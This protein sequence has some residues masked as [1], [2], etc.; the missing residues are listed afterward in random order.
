MCLWLT[1][2][3]LQDSDSRDIISSPKPLLTSLLLVPAGP[4]DSLSEIQ[5]GHPLPI[6]P[7]TCLPYFGASHYLPLYLLFIFVFH[8]HATRLRCNKCLWTEFSGIVL[9]QAQR[10]WSD[11]PPTTTLS[12]PPRVT[13]L[14]GGGEAPQLGFLIFCTALCLRSPDE[15]KIFLWSKCELVGWWSS[16]SRHCLGSEWCST[17]PL[18]SPLPHPLEA[19]RTLSFVLLLSL[20]LPADLPIHRHHETMYSISS[21]PFKLHI[22]ERILCL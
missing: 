1:Q 12:P 10:W 8:V 15:R 6:C 14:T 16:Y 5:P 2:L 20:P 17:A 21:H 22:N 7:F 13:H 11:V 4:K 18:P 9:N 3:F 19:T